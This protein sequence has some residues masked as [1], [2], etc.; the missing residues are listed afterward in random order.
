[1]KKIILAVAFIAAAAINANAQFGK[2]MP[3]ETKV[4]KDEKTGVALKVLT[5][6][7][8]ND[9]F[10][11]Q[12]DP[13][14]TP[15]GKYL[16]FRSSSR[17]T[18][19]SVM[20]G[21]DGQER[22]FPMTY[23]YFIE[24]STGRIIQAMDKDFNGSAFL[25]NKSNKMFVQRRENEAWTMYVMDLDKLFADAEAGKA[26][27][28]ADYAT[29]IGVFPDNVAK[30]GRPGSFCINS[31]D[32]VAYI[33]V[34]REVSEEQMKAAQ[35]KAF[36]PKDNQPVKVGVGFSGICKMNLNNGEVQKICDIDFR[37]GHIQASRFDP[38]EVVFC[39]ETGGDAYQRMWFL[40]AATG[41]YRELYKETALDW[42]TH[43]TFGTKDY[44]YFNVLGWQP[45]LRKQVNGIFRVN[46]R[47]DDVDLIGQVEMDHDGT[48]YDMKVKTGRGFWHCNSSRDNKWAAGDT[49]DSSVWLINVATGH[50][51]H[52]ASDLK[53]APDHAQPFFSPDGT[54]LCFQS[55]HYSDAKR[56][57][58]VMVDLTEQP[59]YSQY[60]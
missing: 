6:T 46:L 22:K 56:L 44:V 37:V 34:T 30:Y 18:D 27:K 9:R 42:V 21:R 53:M 54:K 16:L 7:E 28:A 49:F 5:N 32:N 15:D 55:G 48:N 4:M 29:K 40:D 52:I 59:F 19:E 10:L 43:E 51:Y 36:K 2:W 57:N 31:D 50:K 24:V 23:V 14:W 12:T 1:M 3:S 38:D 45:E 13:M 58:L 17:T 8:L 20:T 41:Q 60:E 39:W 25:A 33:T 47:T 26:T 35:E 11:Y